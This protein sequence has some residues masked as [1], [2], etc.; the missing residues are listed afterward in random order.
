MAKGKEEIHEK[1]LKFASKS[2]QK[3]DFRKMATKSLKLKL[4][5]DD[6]I[7]FNEYSFF[8]YFVHRKIL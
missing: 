8:G 2:E 3:S 4:K 6:Q 7:F 5:N 1:S